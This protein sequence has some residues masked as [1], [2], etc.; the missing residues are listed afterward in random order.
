MANPPVTS[1]TRTTYFIDLG[2]NKVARVK[3]IKTSISAL[4]ASLGW[5]EDADGVPPQGKTLVGDGIEDA[6]LNGCFPIALYYT[7]NKQKRRA[8]VLVSPTKADTIATEAR[9]KT[10]AG[11]PVISVRPVRRRKFTY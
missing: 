8:V 6:L 11:N 7:K 9:G 2:N 10:Y 1:R 3:A 4:T 5:T